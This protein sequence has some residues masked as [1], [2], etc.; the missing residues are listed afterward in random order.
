[1]T[2]LEDFF[3]LIIAIYELSLSVTLPYSAILLNLE[4]TYMYTVVIFVLHERSL[5]V[6]HMNALF[7]ENHWKNV[8]SSPS[9]SSVITWAHS[10]YWC[11]QVT[12]N[13]KS[14][15]PFSKNTAFMV[16][17]RSI[18]PVWKI[19]QNLHPEQK[20]KLLN[21]CADIGMMLINSYVTMLIFWQ[22]PAQKNIPKAEQKYTFLW[23][24]VTLSYFPYWHPTCFL[25]SFWVV[26]LRRNL[27]KN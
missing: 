12:K 6:Y 21:S 3:V 16:R 22:I 26:H 18:G 7:L 25:F 24:T 17:L 8:C 10:Y 5:K 15:L 20:N 2:L 19:R 4:Y 23:Y 27:Q 9:S 14:V 13:L 1:M 11:V